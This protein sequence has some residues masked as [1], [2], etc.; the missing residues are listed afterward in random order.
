MRRKPVRALP[1]L[2]ATGLCVAPLF[3]GGFT[4]PDSFPVLEPGEVTGDPTPPNSPAGG[5]ARHSM[6]CGMS[7]ATRSA[8]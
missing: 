6:Y 1:V 5:I 2:L 3:R 8:P 4:V 7:S